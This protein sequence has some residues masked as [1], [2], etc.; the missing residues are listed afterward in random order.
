MRMGRVLSNVGTVMPAAL[1]FLVTGGRDVDLQFAHTRL[2]T[3]SRDNENKG[4]LLGYAEQQ[5]QV[6]ATCRELD[7]PLQ[8]RTDAAS[9]AQLF[10]FTHD[11]RANLSD[12]C[13]ARGERSGRINGWQAVVALGKDRECGGLACLAKRGGT[14][15]FPGFFRGE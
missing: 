12:T 3:N 15:D 10:E 1:A 6:L 5:G 2:N 4:E 9:R 7:F 13:P 8:R 14:E 11:L